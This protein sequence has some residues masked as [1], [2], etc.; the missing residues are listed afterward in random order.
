QDEIKIRLRP[1]HSGQNATTICILL[2]DPER[3]PS[4]DPA[5]L[6]ICMLP[7]FSHIALSYPELAAVQFPAVRSQVEPVA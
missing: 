4:D 7:C 6:K 2:I 3:V 1:S 5:F